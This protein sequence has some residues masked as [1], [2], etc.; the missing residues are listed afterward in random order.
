MEVLLQF[1]NG[2][3]LAGVPAMWNGIVDVRD[4]ADAHIQAA[5]NPAAEGRYFISGGTLSLL[6]MGKISRRST[7][8]SKYPSP[9]NASY[10]NLPLK[11][12][13]LYLVFPVNLWN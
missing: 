13:A 4:V 3:T 10:L 1:A 12:L 8:G 11:P 5:F 7:L 6:E 2:M 9:R